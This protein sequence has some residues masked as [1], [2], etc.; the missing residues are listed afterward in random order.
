MHDPVL[1]LVRTLAARGVT[2]SFIAGRLRYRAPRG[3]ITDAEKRTLSENAPIVEAILNP[4]LT[5]PAVLVIPASVP[6]T[7]EAID[8]CIDAQRR[9][10]AQHGSEAAA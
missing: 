5:L 3:R 1:A 4:D 6:N 9:K 7:V 2:L 10:A 8:A